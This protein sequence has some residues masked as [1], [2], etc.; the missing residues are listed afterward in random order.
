V[1]A[2]EK[3]EGGPSGPSTLVEGEV[4]GLVVAGE[5][6]FFTRGDGVY[7]L[8]GGASDVHRIAEDRAPRDL[9]VDRRSVYWIS[10]SSHRLFRAPRPD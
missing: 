4:T 7:F 1:S 8:A 6:V 3:G 5:N 2:A 9:V 10:S